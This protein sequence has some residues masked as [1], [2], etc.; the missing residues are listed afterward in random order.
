MYENIVKTR[1]LEKV[2]NIKV[3]GCYDIDDLSYTKKQIN[4]FK[5][6]KQIGKRTHVVIW[7]IIIV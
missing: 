4:N 7:I 1:Y 5:I 2:T 3:F 6:N